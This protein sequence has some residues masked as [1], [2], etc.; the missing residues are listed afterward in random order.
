MAFIRPIQ[1]RSSNPISVIPDPDDPYNKSVIF[2]PAKHKLPLFIKRHTFRS[3]HSGRNIAFYC[4]Q[5]ENEKAIILGGSGLKH[6]FPLPPDQVKKLNDAGYS[7]LWVGLPN[8]VRNDNFVNHFVHIAEELLTDP[9]NH[10]MRQWLSRDVPK[11]FFGYSTTAQLFFHLL[12]ENRTFETLTNDFTGA[13]LMS[14]YLRPPGL[15]TDDSLR[16]RALRRAATKHPDYVSVETRIGAGYF[17]AGKEDKVDVPSLLQIARNIP[18][19]LN[20]EL[21]EGMEYTTPTF[22]QMVELMDHGAIILKDSFDPNSNICNR[23]DFPILMLN[24]KKDS[25]AGAEI[26]RG[27]AE[28][29]NIALYESPIAKHAVAYDDPQAIQIMITGYDSMLS[30]T[31]DQMAK[32]LREW[33]QEI[34]QDPKKH[35]S[36]LNHAATSASLESSA[37]HAA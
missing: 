12:R 2:N 7:Y 32:A 37:L 1:E 5:A 20:P 31:F 15:E 28:R 9:Q 33:D 36:P 22:Q 18:L 4:A 10:V 13:A 25:Y 11:F 6:D 30:G 29:A 27:F 8:P 17:L 14:T 35:T 34:Q 3:S 23:V 16:A 19:R 24:G 26:N 21:A